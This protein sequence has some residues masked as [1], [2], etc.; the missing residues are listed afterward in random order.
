MVREE[1][2]TRCH[3][4][5]DH[6]GTIVIRNSALVLVFCSRVTSSSIASGGFMSLSTRRRMQTRR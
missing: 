6:P 3:G 5:A 2:A 1:S 4:C